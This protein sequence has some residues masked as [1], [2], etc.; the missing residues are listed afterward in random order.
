MNIIYVVEDFSENGGVERIVSQKTNELATHYGHKVAIISVYDDPRP[1]LYRLCP[2]VELIQLG[3]PFAAKGKGRIATLASRAKTLLTAIQRL[4]KTAKSLNPDIIFFTTTLG[5]LLLPFCRTKA[6]KVYESHL[7]RI[8]NPFHSLFWLTERKADAI[9]CLTSGDAN[10]FKHAKD[11]RIIPNFIDKPQQHIGD[12]GVKRAIAVGRLEEQK[13]FDI[14]IGCWPDIAKEHPD[15]H[16]DIYGEGSCHNSLQEQ[17]EGLG[18]QQYITLCGRSNNIMDVY[19]QY[20]L[21][22]MPSRYEG[23]G[24]ALIEAQA[25]GL[26]SVATDFIYGATDIITNGS[27]GIVVEQG[28]TKALTDAISRMM[29]SEE[30]RR[31][32]GAAAKATAQKYFKENVFGMWTELIKT[33]F[34]SEQFTI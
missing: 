30:L 2:E 14:L 25:C 20:S 21:H 8:F 6:K 4:N 33:L 7:A 23:Q 24:I 5:A 12:Y 29:A 17:I 22:I 34:L 31:K 19:P 27:N 18:M 32:Y 9:V 1:M 15:W 11:V 3:V 26:P 28:N 10:C 13:G 16:L